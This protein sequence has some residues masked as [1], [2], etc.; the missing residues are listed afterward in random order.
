MSHRQ[1]PLVLSVGTITVRMEIQA[2]SRIQNS[3]HS[4]CERHRSQ[5]STTIRSPGE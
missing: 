3:M 2:K 1:L 4:R 5:G